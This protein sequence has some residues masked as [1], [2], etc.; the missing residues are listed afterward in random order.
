MLRGSPLIKSSPF[1]C[2]TNFCIS[3]LNYSENRLAPRTSL[4]PSP[5]R[6]VI[7]RITS[8]TSS[9]YTQKIKKNN[10]SKKCAEN[11]LD[12]HSRDK[13]RVRIEGQNNNKKDTI[14]IQ[15]CSLSEEC[16]K[17]PTEKKKNKKKSNKNK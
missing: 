11:H 1:T 16:R 2:L 7:S 12:N 4:S 6:K 17:N 3:S 8:H 14:Q 13:R 9:I 15:M 10:Y 5:S